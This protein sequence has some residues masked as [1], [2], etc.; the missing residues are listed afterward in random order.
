MDGY[1]A[2][3]AARLAETA[4]MAVAALVKEHV[5]DEDQRVALFNLSQGQ[6]SSVLRLAAEVNCEH[7][8]VDRLVL[9][10]LSDDWYGELVRMCLERID[11]EGYPIRSLGATTFCVGALGL[12]VAMH[13]LLLPLVA[14]VPPVK[15]AVTAL[16]EGCNP[17]QVRRRDRSGDPPFP[18]QRL[19]H[20]PTPSRPSLSPCLSKL[21]SPPDLGRRRATLR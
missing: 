14:L 10:Q 1:T 16:F 2:N 18:S 13:L 3:E 4:Q 7:L 15:G 9:A 5:L 11:A 20:T 17:P 19:P 8:L 12:A 6:A 21:G